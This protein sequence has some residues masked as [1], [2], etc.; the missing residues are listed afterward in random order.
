MEGELVMKKIVGK[1]S[2]VLALAAMIMSCSYS[3]SDVNSDSYNDSGTGGSLARFTVAG[4]YLYTVDENSLNVF[5]ITNSE[6]PAFVNEKNLGFGAETIFPKGENLFIGTSTGMFIYDISNRRNPSQLS[7]FEHV[8]ACDPVVADDDFAYVTLNSNNQR[9]WRWTN[10]LQIID[11]SDV[12]NPTLKK[13]YQ[14]DG[15]QG[16]GIKND[17]LWVCDNGLKLYDVSD[18]ENIQLLYQNNTIQVR[19][20]I[21]NK[22][23]LMTIGD[24]GFYQFELKNNQINELSKLLIYE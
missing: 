2:I 5:N 24:D 13:T 4:D 17:S 8:M 21:L 1:I 3:D 19:D 6:Q 22:N 16:L 10:E 11:I 12:S 23:L 14:M 20:V 9:C 18:K 15:P 7:Y